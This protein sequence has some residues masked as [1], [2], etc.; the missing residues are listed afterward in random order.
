MISGIFR[1][2]AAGLALLAAQPAFAEWHEASSDHFVIYADDKDTDLRKFAEH[3]HADQF[4]HAVIIDCSASAAVASRY[5]HW[6][7]QGIHVVTACKLGQGTSLERWR[8]I[9]SACAEGSTHYG[10]SAPDAA[11]ASHRRRAH[12]P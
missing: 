3:V 2:I 9:R 10:D 8:T 6:L 5:A 12:G 1:L 7:S 11:R 4:P